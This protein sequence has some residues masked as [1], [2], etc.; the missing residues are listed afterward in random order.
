MVRNMNRGGTDGSLCRALQDV[1]TAQAQ[2]GVCHPKNVCSR[3]FRYLMVFIMQ[4][5]QKKKKSKT[6]KKQKN[7]NRAR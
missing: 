3:R 6:P 2:R 7:S 4:Q 1:E 5:T